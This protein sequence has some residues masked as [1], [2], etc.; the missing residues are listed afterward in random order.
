M[1]PLEFVRPL[2]ESELEEKIS[3]PVCSEYLE[4]KFKSSFN[5]QFDI[6][7]KKKLDDFIKLW[8]KK[9]DMDLTFIRCEFCGK[10]IVIRKHKNEV[11]FNGLNGYN[12][13][14]PDKTCNQIFYLTKCPE[15]ESVQKIKNYVKEGNVIICNNDSCKHE[16]IQIKCPYKDCTDIIYN[17][18]ETSK[19]NFPNGVI[20]LHKKAVIYQKI[21]CINCFR[22]ILYPSTAEIKNKYIEGQK[23]ECQYDDCKKKF[24]RLICP[25][26]TNENYVNDGWYEMGSLIKCQ[27]CTKTFGKIICP[28]CQ[29]INIC[30]N[31]FFKSGTN[32][33]SFSCCSKEFNMTN[34]L[35][36]RK[37]N[38]LDKNRNLTG[39]VVKCGYCGNTFNKI[40]CPSCNN[41]N[42]F[43]MADFCLGKI[44]K[45]IYLDCLKQ[46]Q[47][48]ICPKCRK[49]CFITEKVEGQKLFCKMCNSSFM[50]WA[51]PFCKSNIMDLNSSFEFGQM[52]KCPNHTCQK[53]Y[54]FIRC[55]GCM[56]LIFSKENEPL[57]GKSIKCPDKN[58]SKRTMFLQCPLCKKKIIYQG[59]KDN[60]KEGDLISCESCKKKYNFSTNNTL[61]K[62]NLY[63]LEPFEGKTIRLGE[64]KK[65]EKYLETQNL[66]FYN[67]KYASIW[68]SKTMSI[69]MLSIQLFG[70]CIVCHNDHRESVF[71]PCGHRCACYRCAVQ[72]FLVY[73]KCPK[74]Q[75]ASTCIIKK[76]YE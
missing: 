52:V 36:C 68:V 65:D 11:E 42:P 57:L 67:Q 34:C 19:R 15:C 12:I 56:K 17:D 23:I 22:P 71:V 43:P 6:C 14:C 41:I 5:N 60:I 37:L 44:Y 63:I 30:F 29:K 59:N 61:Y 55:N 73:K 76:V 33:W 54:T 58:C 27:N 39:E 70:E 20:V 8:C 18:K 32:K 45:C 64:P 48:L 3:C 50:N 46:F 74:C 40:Y 24:N 38:V 10:P 13:Q 49:S 26:C 28:S 66:F 51:C 35:Y 31:D 25:I 2:T 69:K 72:F 4:I 9:C 21:E 1:D 47:L 62:G 75:T 53:K 16:Y 7:K